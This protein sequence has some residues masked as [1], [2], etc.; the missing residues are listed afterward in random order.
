DGQAGHLAREVPQRH[1]DETQG[2]DGELL[3]AV[4]LPDAVPPPLLLQ[5]VLANQLVAQ[6]ALDEVGHDHAAVRPGPALDAVVGDHAQHGAGAG[7]LRPRQ[8]CAPPKRWPRRSRHEMGL[9]VDDPH[10]LS[11]LLS[12]AHKT[13]HRG[14]CGPGADAACAAPIIPIDQTITPT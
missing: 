8:P 14:P 3:D 5:W 10:Y 1:V 9:H 4:E 13:R 7:L 11:L 6:T 2:I 12:S